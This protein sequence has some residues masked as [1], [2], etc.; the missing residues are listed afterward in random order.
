MPRTLTLSATPPFAPAYEAAMQRQQFAVIDV[1][2]TEGD[3][4]R[5]RVM[6]V[7]AIALDGSRERM[8]WE[9]LVQPRERVPWFTRKLTGIDDSML[10]DAPGF[11]EIAGTLSTITQDRIVVAHNVRFD[12]TALRHEFARTG[13]AFER[14]TLCTE[15][16]SRRLMP[17]LAHHNLS[18]VCRHLGIAFPKAHRALADAEATAEVLKRMIIEFG[19]DSVLLGMQPEHLAK[20]A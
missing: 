5:G 15:R 8:R 2:V 6:E 17:H 16:V 18:S 14:A 1:E 9:S 13:L 3:P 7:A 20:R 4:T 12:M 10:R 11:H 19:T